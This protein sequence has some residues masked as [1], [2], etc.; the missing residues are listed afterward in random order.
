MSTV[1]ANLTPGPCLYEII[2]ASFTKC[3]IPDIFEIGESADPQRDTENKE[4][5]THGSNTYLIGRRNSKFAR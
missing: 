2:I 1:S 5:L 3:S 4:K